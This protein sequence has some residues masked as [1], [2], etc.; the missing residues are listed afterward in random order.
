VLPRQGLEPNVNALQHDGIDLHFVSSHVGS[1]A[2]AEPLDQ[3]Q[4]G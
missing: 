2:F 4:N 1:L 3:R